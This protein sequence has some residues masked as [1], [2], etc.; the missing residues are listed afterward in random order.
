MK[1][2]IKDLAVYLGKLVIKIGAV[3]LIGVAISYAIYYIKG[4]EFGTTMRIVGVIIAVIG[5]GSQLGQSNI[6]M[7][8]NY[9]MAKMRDSSMQAREHDG[10]MTAGS[11][12]FLI[13]MGT[14]GIV[15]FLIGDA[16]IRNA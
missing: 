1:A 5:L 4:F 12:S 6:R 3:V 9:N 14:S 8:Y 10:F 2:F 7:D 13:W 16:I 15:L 11:L